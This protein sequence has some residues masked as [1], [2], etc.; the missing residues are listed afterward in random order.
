MFSHCPFRNTSTIFHILCNTTATIALYLNERKLK[1]KIQSFISEIKLFNKYSSYTNRKHISCNL[2]VYI[3]HFKDNT[4]TRVLHV[5][6]QD[7]CKRFCELN[8]FEVVQDRSSNYVQGKLIKV[9][10]GVKVSLSF[11]KCKN[12]VCF[13]RLSVTLWF[14]NN[15]FFCA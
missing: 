15:E 5:L 12:K 10:K 1:C 13:I 11:F 2:Q 3:T 6:F 4:K 14:R 9:F 8:N 7:I